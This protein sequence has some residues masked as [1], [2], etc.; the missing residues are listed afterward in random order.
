[1]DDFS[2]L[3]PHNWWQLG[4]CD[5]VLQKM[6][7]WPLKWNELQRP[8][9]VWR[10]FVFSLL[11]WLCGWVTKPFQHAMFHVK[12]LTKALTGMPLHLQSSLINSVW[13]YP[14]KVWLKVGG[15]F[16]VK[17]DFWHSVQRRCDLVRYFKVHLAWNVRFRYFLAFLAFS[18]LSWRKPELLGKK[19]NALQVTWTIFSKCETFDS[20]CRLWWCKRGEKGRKMLKSLK[21][22][23]FDEEGCKGSFRKPANYNHFFTFS[24]IKKHIR[25]ML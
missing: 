11:F 5:A 25:F 2:T 7:D 17:W 6:F 24:P 19:D 21:Q 14:K 10:A 22:R 18:F 4:R 13:N 9:Q 20:L 16:D 3:S 8:F 15:D 12:Y 23:A 1:M